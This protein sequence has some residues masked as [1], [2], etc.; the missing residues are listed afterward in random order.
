MCDQFLEQR[1][2]ITY[3]V[4]LGENASETCAFLSQNYGWEAMK[5][6]TVSE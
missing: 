1:M 5:K 2:D 3:C 4:K 6:S